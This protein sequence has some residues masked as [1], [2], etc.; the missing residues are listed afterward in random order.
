MPQRWRHVTIEGPIGVGKTSLAQRLAAH[1]QATTLLERPQDNTF[2]VR[3][4]EEPSRYALQ[5]QLS[6]LFQRIEQARM[7]Q[8]TLFGGGLVADFLFGKNDLFAQLTLTDEEYALYSTI[9][10]HFAPHAAT[11]DLVIWLQADPE[12]LI[13]RIRQRG[14]GM[15]RAIGRD[16]LQ[17][18]CEAYARFFHKF[19]AAPVLAVNTNQ[20]DPTHNSDDFA[21]L[22]QHL[23]DFKGR[24]GFLHTA[25]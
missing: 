11:P 22:M 12:V 18:L 20:F 17:R 13:G 21:V 4:Y 15:E 6:F 5:T 24:R 25:R 3:Y 19:D 2:L 7:A 10:R 9:D 16:Y 1:W 23:L 8:P 14:I